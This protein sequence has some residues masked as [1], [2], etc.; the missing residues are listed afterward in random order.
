MDKEI[1]FSLMNAFID[2]SK[3]RI[4]KLVDDPEFDLSPVLA[5]FNDYF[6]T[7]AVPSVA[8]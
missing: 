3:D 8:F 5:S 7:D 4:Q 1:D 2:N 6:I